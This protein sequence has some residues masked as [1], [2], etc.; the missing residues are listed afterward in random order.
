MDRL[1]TFLGQPAS[2]RH[3]AHR[4]AIEAGAVPLFVDR[5]LPA[6][7][8]AGERTG[9]RPDVLVAQ[10][11]HETGGG[12]FGRAVTP[13]HHNTAGIKVPEPGADDAAD[14]HQRFD[15]WQ[16]GAEAHANHLRWPYAG[17]DP[18]GHVAPRSHRTATASWAG[19]ITT[20]E[21]LSGKWAPSAT[22]HEPILRNLEEMS[23]MAG[24]YLVDN[25]PRRSQYRKPRRAAPTGTIVLHTA[26]NVPDLNPP[27][28]GAERIAEFIRN[29]S[30]AGSYHTICDQD[31]R[32][33]LV[34]FEWEAFGDGTG[35][36]PWAIHISAALRAEDWARLTNQQRLWYV[37]SMATASR[38]ASDWLLINHGI[39]VPVR[40]LTKASAT[41]P[42]F[43]SHQDRETWFGKPGRRT[44]PWRNDE[45]MWLLFLNLYADT[46]HPPQGDDEMVD[47]IVKLHEAYYSLM[48]GTPDWLKKNQHGKPQGPASVDWHLAAYIAGRPLG[49]IR[50]DFAR[51]VGL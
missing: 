21:G 7:W 38:E 30:D 29:R 4:W 46:A 3:H 45:A 24:F 1:T 19:T 11:F 5:I 6:L 10:S 42:G 15:T 44:D 23:D 39:E 20:V 14:S 12:R 51:T 13:E 31:S 22:Y 18:I 2:N 40:R 8:A 41:E 32:I 33:R 50:K 25:P 9:I 28:D 17:L 27:D 35:S 36:N 47:D 48:P 43:C 37:A 26:E 49:E 16:H 34:P